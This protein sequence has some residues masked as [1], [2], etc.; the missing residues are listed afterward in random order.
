[1]EFLLVSQIN[2]TDASGALCTEQ[3]DR[4][5]DGLA[6]AALD[7]RHTT[8]IRVPF[9]PAKNFG[10]DADLLQWLRL[11]VHAKEACALGCVTPATG[12]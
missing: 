9:R 11:I 2:L 4:D 3:T 10:G 7:A 6:G 5:R 1:M 12:G 8:L